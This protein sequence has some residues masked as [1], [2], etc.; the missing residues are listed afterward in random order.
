MVRASECR[1]VGG[2]VTKMSIVSMSADTL[3]RA[4]ED[5]ASFYLFDVRDPEDFETGHIPGAILVPFTELKDH[6]PDFKPD[7]RY[8][9]VCKEGNLSKK[10]SKCMQSLGFNDVHI[11]I[12]GMVTW[13]RTIDKRLE[14]Y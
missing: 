6:L 8:V 11:L 14:T 3:K 1:Y 10:A 7:Q 9:L 12:G 4:L 2:V 5:K 13:I